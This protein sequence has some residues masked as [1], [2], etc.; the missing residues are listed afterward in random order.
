MR[1]IQF[2]LIFIVWCHSVSAQ[3]STQNS[4]AP[5]FLCH[6]ECEPPD[7][8]RDSSPISCFD[9]KHRRLAT[10]GACVK[11]C[12]NGYYAY[13]ETIG[14]YKYKLCGPCH[15]NC[16]EC[17]GPRAFQCQRCSKGFYLDN[18]N[19]FGGR[20][21]NLCRSCHPS[22]GTCFGIGDYT[23]EFTCLTCPDGK[24]KLLRY[25]RRVHRALMTCGF[26]NSDCKTCSGP[27][28][29]ECLSCDPGLILKSRYSK[30]I[31]RFGRYCLVITV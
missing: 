28:N 20:Y 8:C 23:S 16:D 13:Q 11:E 25:G 5:S 7:R 2:F 10:T 9:C 19:Y 24:Y 29:D 4:S 6:S 26:C 15:T 31:R 17:A 21:H 18:M 12:P 30:R 27:G 1:R 14:F 22:C 3:N